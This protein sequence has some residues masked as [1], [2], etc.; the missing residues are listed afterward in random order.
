MQN[1]F[2]KIVIN[3]QY[4]RLSLIVACLERFNARVR[5]RKRQ[6]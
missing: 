1:S 5:I 6:L 4:G 2:A 3:C